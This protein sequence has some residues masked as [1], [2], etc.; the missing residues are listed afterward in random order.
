MDKK[1]NENLKFLVAL[2]SV[3]IFVSLPFG[4]FVYKSLYGMLA[5]FGLMAALG[6]FI[7]W[8]MAPKINKTEKT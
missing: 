1:L 4:L 5:I 8:F 2:V 7:V 6:S 3:S